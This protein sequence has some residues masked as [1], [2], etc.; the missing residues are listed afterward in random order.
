MAPEQARGDREKVDRRSDVYGLG[1]TLYEL[2]TG[3]PPFDGSPDTQVLLER[4]KEEDAPPVRSRAH[5]VPSALEAIV[6]VALEKEPARRYATAGAMADDLDRFLAGEPVHARPPG[7]LERLQRLAR[8]RARLLA[9]AVALLVGAVVSVG[10]GIPVQRRWR[11]DALVLK[12]S[13][14]ERGG[15]RDEA[16]ALLKE[17]LG[18]VPNL[19]DARARL[20][21]F[22]AADGNQ[23]AA[24]AALDRAIEDDPE[25]LEARLLRA[26][27]ETG[28]RDLDRALADLE[29]ADRAAPRDPR[30]AYE[31]GA[32][33]AARGRWDDAGAELDRGLE[34]ARD[35]RGRAPDDKAYRD[36]LRLA[37]EARLRSGDFEH[38]QTD[39]EESIRLEPN[40]TQPRVLLGQALVG[41]HKDSL[42]IEAFSDALRRQPDDPEALEL[43]AASLRRVGRSADALVDLEAVAPGR[44]RA[45]LL[46]GLIR[47]ETPETVGE[48]I[49]F[50]LGRARED[51]LWVLGLDRGPDKGMSS[52]DAPSPRAPL[53]PPEVA[54]AFVA[55][56]WI[57]LAGGEATAGRLGRAG[58]W[59]DE[60]A[61]VAPRDPAIRLARG[62]ILVRTRTPARAREDLE[63]ARADP[64]LAYSALVGLAK[65]AFAQE[66]WDES[67]ALAEQAIQ[68]A[69]TRPTAHALRARLLA[70]AGDTEGARG[71]QKAAAGEAGAENRLPGQAAPVRRPLLDLAD[72]LEA[73]EC[74]VARGLESF[75][76]ALRPGSASFVGNTATTARQGASAHFG[77]AASQAGAYLRRALVLD[78][79]RVA[80]VQKLADTLYV[81]GKT[82]E[83]WAAYGRVLELDPSLVEADIVRGIMERDLIAER[84]PRRAVATLEGAI[85]KLEKGPP[86]ADPTLGGRALFELARA[87]EQAG[88]LDKALACCE[89]AC[90]ITPSRHA[91]NALRAR[92]LVRLKRPEAAQAIEVAAALLRRESQPAERDRQNLFFRAGEL[93]DGL[94]SR[95]GIHF[96]TRA[97]EAAPAVPNA[98]RGRGERFSRHRPSS[99]RARSWTW[100]PPW[101]CRP[102]TRTPWSTSRARSSASCPTRPSWSSRS[103]S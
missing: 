91:P 81:L 59:L 41:L 76:G 7:P 95:I 79:D 75:A 85:A 58:H 48:E 18:M 16:R 8:K 53:E 5:E 17:A 98:W 1:A 90:R 40:S 80:P 29:V 102:T 26:Q 74:A 57:E 50:D 70:R 51:L 103:R 10:L 45:R 92:L 49:E 25:S 88:E 6:S 73:A 84:E 89:E 32:I 38:A 27:L 13:N 19:S 64:A 55:L 62:L 44:A 9:G 20:A 30:A 66:K 94:D 21:A 100:R 14:L 93:S 37:G 52:G 43:R 2:L 34:L 99:F 31:R 83:A 11:A 68:L 97:I 15:R 65:L 28:A 67:R 3:G 22:D 24:R 54:R 4:I 96:Y 12:A 71:D 39:L 56:A 47:A 23:E 72:P 82:N 69:P 46:R 86:P 61:S 36:A 42:A 78:P 101:S 87:W 35:V 60:A 77:L 33:L 63:A